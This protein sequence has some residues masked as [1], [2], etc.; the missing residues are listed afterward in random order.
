M[1]PEPGTRLQLAF[2]TGQSDPAR[3][4]LSPAQRAFGEALLAPGRWLQP[5]NF[6][7]RPDAAPH[8]AVPL[9]RASWHNGRQYLMSRRSTFAQQHRHGLQAMLQNAPHTVLLAGSCGL[10]LLANLALPP[11]SLDRISVFAYGPVA[12]R[13]PAVAALEVVVG[14]G[15]WMSRLGWPG[16]AT[17]VRSGHLGYL[18]Q[19][20][21][22]ALAR[23]FV[24]DTEAQLR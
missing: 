4:A 22:L 9:L 6:P 5:L 13:A 17:R 18:D 19:P 15:D 21:V 7:Y 10:E 16:V 11:D 3:C 12:R 8:R 23:R 24:D 2:L 1:R 20:A 14:D